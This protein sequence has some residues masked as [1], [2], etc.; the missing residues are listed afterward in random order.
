MLVLDEDSRKDVFSLILPQMCLNRYYVAEGVRVY[1]QETWQL[2]LKDKGKTYV[3]ILAPHFVEYYIR[4]CGA[5]N[6]AV[7]EAACAC[8]AELMAKVESS[9]IREF[10]PRLL[11]ALVNCFKD[12]SWPVRDAAC[13]ACGNCVI[14]FPEES[15]AVLSE[16][17]DLW[18]AH[19]WD[20]IR[21]VRENSAVALGNVIRA[22]GDDALEKILPVLRDLMM[23]VSDQPPDSVKFSG[24]ENSTLFGVARIRDQVSSA[25]NF[26]DQQMFSCGSLAPKLARG[27]GCMDHGFSREKEPWE[28]SDGSVYLVR[29]VALIKPTASAE[30]LPGLAEL[31]AISGF[32][33]AHN[34]R[35]SV[36]KCLPDIAISLGKRAFKPHL[37]MFIGPLFKSV[38]CGQQLEE[39]AAGRAIGKLMDL[40]G[41]SIF[42]G[43]LDTMQKE[44]L[45]S[46][47]NIPAS[48]S[49]II[50]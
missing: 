36:W 23:R 39:V 14:A 24:L 1:S 2:V 8:I 31:V 29:E 16:L 10:V 12:A 50:V 35:E 28:A 17:Y 49:Y 27:G 3:G 45:D 21:S 44:I 4:Q 18:F 33:H 32:T 43:R 37:E 30:F 13:E 42:R 9:C 5:N 22:Y 48:Q 15:K 38:R 34:L 40:I 20:N 19:L 46:N 7:R 25:A 11:N 26:T 41:P 6:H 47:Q